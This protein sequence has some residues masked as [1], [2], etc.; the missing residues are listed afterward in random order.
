MEVLEGAAA[1]GAEVA[2]DEEALDLGVLRVEARREERARGDVAAVVGIV[3]ASERDCYGDWVGERVRGC[4]ELVWEIGG[5]CGGGSWELVEL[6]GA[7][8][9]MPPS[10]SLHVE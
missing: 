3:S 5:E 1:V 4:G 6:M 2:G 8:C 10:T 7:Y 9:E